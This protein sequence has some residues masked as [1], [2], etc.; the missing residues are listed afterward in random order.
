MSELIVRASRPGLG[1][2]LF[3]LGGIRAGEYVAEYTGKHIPTPYAD[4]LKNRYLFEV[5]E[6]WTV[7]GSSKSNIARYLNHSCAPNCE[8]DICGDRILIFAARDVLAGEELTIDYG[9]EYFGEFIRPIGCKCEI[10]LSP[11]GSETS[12]LY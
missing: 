2:G 5:N 7:D 8:A 3:T 1:K 10:C 12:V 4:T 9:E 11:A 6:V